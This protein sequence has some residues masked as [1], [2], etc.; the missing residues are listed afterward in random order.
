MEQTNP[1][2]LQDIE[3]DLYLEPVSAGLRFANYL[4]DVVA[5]YIIAA[6]VGGIW[7]VSMAARGASSVEDAQGSVG[8]L[9]LV[10]FALFIAYYTVFEGAT[11]GRTLGKL[12][13]KTVV[14]KANGGPITFKD[15][16][17]RTLC[18]F[19]PFEPFSAFGGRPW[20]DTITKT[21]VVKKT[22]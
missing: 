18:R 12:V 17:L 21:M 3:K 5:F 2:Y 20:H 14:V 4:I 9:Y 6:I 7:G 22:Q 8:M 11:N 15:A 10:S 1:D 19:I 16:F 13:T